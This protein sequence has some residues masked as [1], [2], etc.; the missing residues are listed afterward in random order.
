MKFPKRPAA[1]E[2]R[3]KG[4]AVRLAHEVLSVARYPHID[5]QPDARGADDAGDNGM[6]RAALVRFTVKTHFPLPRE[7]LSKLGI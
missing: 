7:L 2:R 3:S 5:I 4:S 1:P 6:L